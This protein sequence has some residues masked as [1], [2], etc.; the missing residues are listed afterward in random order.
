MQ[1]PSTKI[2]DASHSKLKAI[3]SLSLNKSNLTHIFLYHNKLDTLR[4]F[5]FVHC[6][7]LEI[8]D[9]SQNEI[10]TI[11][12]FAFTSLIKVERL[13]LSKN[14]IRNLEN[15]L[16]RNLT[17]LQWLWL[18]NNQITRISMNIFTETNKRLMTI[19]LNNNHISSI[20]PNA[21]DFL[22]NLKFLFLSGNNCTNSDFKNHVIYNSIAIAYELKN[23]IKKHR[24]TQKY[25]PDRDLSLIIDEVKALREDCQS[26]LQLQNQTLSMY[27]NAVK[28]FLPPTTENPEDDLY[29]EE[30]GN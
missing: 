8:L 16:F 22:I 15:G 13:D 17:N 3:S 24:D 12:S 6:P 19:Y 1:F 18:S 21:F 27:E 23:C 10:A 28:E 7:E 11:E 25:E 29:Y 20:S 30:L 2:L 9:L 5:I 26:S 14:K 4:D